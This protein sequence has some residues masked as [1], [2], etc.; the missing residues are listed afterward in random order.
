MDNKNEPLVQHLRTLVKDLPIEV[1][2]HIEAPALCCG[3]G[4]VAIVKIDRASNPDP[5]ASHPGSKK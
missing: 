1:L 4:T 2:G 5:T 3:S